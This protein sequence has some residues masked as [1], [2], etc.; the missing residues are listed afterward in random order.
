MISLA[1]E[2]ENEE[3][4]EFKEDNSGINDNN[5]ST[6]SQDKTKEA[7]ISS[8]SAKNFMLKVTQA[9]IFSINTYRQ[10]MIAVGNKNNKLKTKTD[11][12]IVFICLCYNCWKRIIVYHYFIWINVLFGLMVK[13]DSLMC[14]L[15]DI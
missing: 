7:F 3:D 13:N 5:K 10:D 8:L 4:E 12:I 14:L 15:L 6:L 9:V 1:K 2:H 11:G